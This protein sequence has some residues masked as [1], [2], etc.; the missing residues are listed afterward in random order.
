MFVSLFEVEVEIGGDF[1]VEKA[2][3]KAL[4]GRQPISSVFPVFEKGKITVLGGVAAW[5]LQIGKIRPLTDVSNDQSGD[6][7]FKK[8]IH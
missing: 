2:R 7:N 4:V 8:S 1:S 3:H 6:A 5:D